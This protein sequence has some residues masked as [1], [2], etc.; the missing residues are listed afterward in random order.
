VKLEQHCRPRVRSSDVA[1]SIAAE[2]PVIA[3]RVC[4]LLLGDPDAL[5]RLL[6]EPLQLSRPNPHMCAEFKRHKSSLGIA[7]PRQ[8]WIAGITSLV[9]G[10]PGIREAGA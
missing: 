8:H 2:E 3:Q 1:L 4:V 6:L 7:T 10:S 9:L 5:G